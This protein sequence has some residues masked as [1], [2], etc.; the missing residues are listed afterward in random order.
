MIAQLQEVYDALP[1][2]ACK[3]L[4]WNSCGPIDMSTVERQRIV[5]LGYEIPQFTEE[6]ARRW[7]DDEPLHCPA[8]NRQSLQCEVYEARPF[9]CRVWG[10]ADSMRCPHGCEATDILDDQQVYDL[11]LRSLEVGGHPGMD[12]NP[13]TRARMQAMLSDP[14]VGP[15]MARFVRGDR[16]VEP[17]IHRLLAQRD[18]R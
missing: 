13:D 10:V 9:I 8:L 18:A 2:I 6:R 14:E 11:L 16:S 7:A 4:C 15:L 12:V 3:G 5:D 1:Q 17:A